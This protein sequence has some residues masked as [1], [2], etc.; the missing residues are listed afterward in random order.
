MYP[1]LTYGYYPSKNFREINDELYILGL[2][3]N[4][5][6]HIWAIIKE[7]HNL[8]KILYYY[9]TEFDRLSITTLYPDMNVTLIPVEDFWNNPE[10]K[11]D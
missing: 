10:M 11:N 7:N 3:P 9:K 4:N 6:E 5:D 8:N 1:N 2:S